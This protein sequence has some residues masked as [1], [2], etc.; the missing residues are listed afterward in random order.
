MNIKLLAIHARLNCLKR[1]YPD[2]YE[3]MEFFPTG[4]TLL[5]A[6]HNLADPE[7]RKELR[8]QLDEIDDIT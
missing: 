7:V 3:N 1:T 6:N 8:K 4:G 2:L 5:L